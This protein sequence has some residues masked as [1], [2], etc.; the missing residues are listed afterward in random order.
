MMKPEIISATIVLSPSSKEVA[1]WAYK[2]LDAFT[3]R[4]CDL[5]TVRHYEDTAVLNGLAGYVRHSWFA[6]KQ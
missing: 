6:D 3:E 1:I 4:G 2:A 5:A